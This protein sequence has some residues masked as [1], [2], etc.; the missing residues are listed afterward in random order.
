[1]SSRV[2]TSNTAGPMS[3]VGQIDSGVPAWSKIK[4]TM[5]ETDFV[6]Q[7]T[8]KQFNWQ[9]TYPGPDGKFGTA[10]D[11]TMLDEMHVPVNKVVRVI[12]K[13]QDVIHSF[14]VP[15]FRVKMD[16][17]PGRYTTLWF[18]ADR[19]GTYHLFCSQ[20]CGAEHS[21]AQAI[22]VEA[23]TPAALEQGRE[24]PASF[25]SAQRPTSSRVSAVSL[26]L[27]GP[28]RIELGLHAPEACVL[29]AYSGPSDER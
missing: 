11:K 21:I 26:Y 20:Y 2:S 4:M 15:A 10:D 27:V 6:V 1:M 14:Y 29:P 17:L 24:F 5:P 13:S 9:V 22:G 8:A 28:P 7:V 25:S 19:I 12:L 18:Q 3:F 23:S 16:V